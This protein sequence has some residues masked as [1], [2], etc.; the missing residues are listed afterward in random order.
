MTAIQHPNYIYHDRSS[1]TQSSI[2]SNNSS[3]KISLSIFIKDL[4]DK[5]SLTAITAVACGVTYIYSSIPGS[6]LINLGAQNIPKIIKGELWRIG[7]APFLHGNLFHLI[8]NVGVLVIDGPK[9]EQRW[10]KLGF[11]TLAVAAVATD[12]FVKIL[13]NF[14]TPSIGFSG[15]LFGM[16]G[17]LAVVKT[18][19][20]IG[21]D[22]NI[23]ETI[24][25][26]IFFG[27][28]IALSG[29]TR[30]D[31]VAHL[32]GLVAGLAF[33]YYCCKN[34]DSFNGRYE[35]PSVVLR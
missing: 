4:N 34:P 1:L 9:V 27:V 19:T 10:G 8:G 31:H 35:N 13:L 5:V 17:A 23:Y 2:A 32:T 16:M 22:P 14:R 33:G 21:L 18:P 25:R 6:Q 28:A 29:I 20:G 12:I 3:T 30:I 26:Q 15:V 24:A 11:V 7:T